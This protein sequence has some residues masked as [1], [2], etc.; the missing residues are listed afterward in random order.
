M[1][2]IDA[3]LADVSTLAAADADPPADAV[4]VR[5]RAF[6]GQSRDALRWRLL[7]QECAR[8]AFW[9]GLAFVPLMAL[10]SRVGA[11]GDVL[12]IVCWL[13]AIVVGTVLTLRRRLQLGQVIDRLSLSP[14]GSDRLAAA[15]EF[16][17]DDPD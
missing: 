3:N 13:I 11:R 10:R 17:S 8:A 7:V 15:A 5:L 12:F 6:L 2:R 4:G 16:M 9:S 14:D 1:A